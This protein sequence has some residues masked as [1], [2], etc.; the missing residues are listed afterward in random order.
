[1]I[2]ARA[3]HRARR[4]PPAHRRM[5]R[6]RPCHVRPVAPGLH[7]PPAYGLDAPR[8]DL[9]RFTFLLGGSDGEDL[10]GRQ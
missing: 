6:R 3:P 2:L 4:D 9:D 5:A 1:M 7:R 8:T 10:F